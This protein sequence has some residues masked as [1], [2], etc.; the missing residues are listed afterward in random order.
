[1]FQFLKK[2]HPQHEV[3]RTWR[4][5]VWLNILCTFLIPTIFLFT[6]EWIH[7]GTLLGG[8][9][10]NHVAPHTVGFVL[11]W[12]FL[13]LIYIFVS[14]L[15]GLHGLATFITA[16]FS[17]VPGVIS[18]FKLEMRGEPFLP[19][20][21]SQVGDFAGV[22]NRVH[23]QIQP[24]MLWTAAI[25][26][27]LVVATC[28]V[29]MPYQRALRFRW[30][31]G[32]AAAAAIAQ[33]VLIFGV[34]LQP[35]VML[36]LHIMPDMWMQDRYYR[37]YGVITGF[38]TNLQALDIEKPEHYSAESVQALADEVQAAAK[39]AQPL[40]ED[41]YAATAQTPMQQPNIIYVMNES[42]WDVSQLEGIEFDRELVPTLNRLKASSAYGKC[43]TPSFGG[44]TCD[45][46]FEAL[47]GF[48]VEHLPAGSK[49]YQQHVTHDMF[50]LPQYLRSEGY[51]TLAVHGYYRKFWSRNTAYPYLGFDTFIAAED[52]I[53]PDKRRGF[54]SDQAMTDRIIEE[55]E[56]R[57]TDKPLFVHAVTM[58]NH[59]T[60]D[61]KNYPADEL[62]QVTKAPQG[63]SELTISQLQDFATG[64]Y[65]G[66]AALGKLIDYFSNVEEPTIIVFWGDH[67]NPLGK[68]YE[69]FE[70]T[71]W[72]EAGDT[73]SPALHG[74]TLMMWSN[75]TD[76]AVDLGT[77]AAY[78]ITPVMMDLYGL[79]KPLYFEFLAQQL[80][81][82]R[83][84]TRGVTVGADGTYS[85]DMTEAQQAVF[86]NQWLLQ[87]DLMFGESY[88]MNYTEKTQ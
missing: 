88:L 7:R 10:Q 26:I 4:A 51:T 19:W 13:V 65:E 86:D 31:I 71:G 32:F 62:V 1:M 60:Y 6:M 68:G 70:K 44:G 69:L 76:A 41:S 42:F 34:Y 14:Q 46:E 64:I 33:C 73:G 11:G 54:I 16:V 75:Y 39:R 83:A 22:A 38:M 12:L 9:W 3:R 85:E 47:T 49:P 52:F 53:N 24:S 55:Y 67:F 82:M 87:Y 45:V 43:Y 78:N 84:R 40:Y 17:N 27:I 72:I 29:K 74:T 25:V 21:I 63:M 80:S 56:N 30:R 18:W 37:N 57:D 15:S 61:S 36:A 20:D 5:S 58:Q 66:D 79:E 59:T 23:L 28:F 35:S 81:V 77:V 50:S 8:F 48:S 2:M